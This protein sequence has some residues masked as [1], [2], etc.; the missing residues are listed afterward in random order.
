MRSA[1]P[2]S[3]L[4]VRRKAACSA[5]RMEIET[6]VNG[7]LCALCPG[8]KETGRRRECFSFLSCGRELFY[9]ISSAGGAASRSGRYSRRMLTAAFTTSSLISV[10]L[11]SFWA[12]C[13]LL[14]SFSLRSVS[15]RIL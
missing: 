13:R 12:F 9:Q 10:R 3:A 1:S 7:V 4:G 5:G 11:A 14:A 8:K 6:M 2:Q 15:A